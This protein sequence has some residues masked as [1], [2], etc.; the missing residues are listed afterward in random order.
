VETLSV[1]TGDD[2]SDSVSQHTGTG[3]DVYWSP[4]A[5]RLRSE[6]ADCTVVWTVPGVCFATEWIV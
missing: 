4:E 6:T 5:A 2:G 1:F 3:G